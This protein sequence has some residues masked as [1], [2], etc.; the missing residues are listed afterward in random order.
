MI[1]NAF[2][3]GPQPT[4]ELLFQAEFA[5]TS[6]VC[7]FSAEYL[8]GATKFE[9]NLIWFLPADYWISS[10]ELLYWLNSSMG[11]CDGAGCWFNFSVNWSS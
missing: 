6:I 4:N 9:L 5:T 8:R 11:L 1:Y 7:K 3:L 2:D 10:I